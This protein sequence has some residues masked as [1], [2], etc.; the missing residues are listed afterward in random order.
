[1]FPLIIAALIAA[2]PEKQYDSLAGEVGDGSTI[3]VHAAKLIR[4]TAYQL[5]ESTHGDC[6]DV[7]FKLEELAF[8]M[9]TLIENKHVR[10]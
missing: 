10:K 8:D 6:A 4:N 1:M 2:C 5:I 9:E 7:V 3:S